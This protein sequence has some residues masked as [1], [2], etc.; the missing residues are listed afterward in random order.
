MVEGT[1]GIIVDGDYGVFSEL[2][3]INGDLLLDDGA[4]ACLVLSTE[5]VFIK[6]VIKL[7]YKSLYLPGNITIESLILCCFNTVYHI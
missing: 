4:E 6:H 3:N 5:L 2:E 1:S 7:I